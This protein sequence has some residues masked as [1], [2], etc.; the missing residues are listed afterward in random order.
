ME[1]CINHIY[2]CLLIAL[3]F[4]VFF[5]NLLVILAV[6]KTKRLRRVT[7]LYIVSLTV[8][9]LLVA[10]LILPFSIIR[11]YYG[12]WPYESHEL[13]LYFLSANIFLCVSSILNVC[14]ISIDRYIAITSPMKYI[15]KRT[16]QTALAMIIFA[17]SAS[18]IAMLP[19]LL[20]AQHHTGV[21]NC[22]V[23][24][25]AWYRILTGAL[26]FYI[27]FPLV[28]FIYLRIFWVIHSRRKAFKSVRFSSKLKEHRYGSLSILFQLNGLGRIKRWLRAD[29]FTKCRLF[30]LHSKKSEICTTY[31]SEN[32]CKQM[33]QITLNFSNKD[34]ISLKET[35]IPSESCS[36]FKDPN[37]QLVKGIS[38]TVTSLEEPIGVVQISL[39][40]RRFRF[41][42]NLVLPN[43]LEKR[44]SCSISENTASIYSVQDD[45]KSVIISTSDQ[46]SRTSENI[47]TKMH[48]KTDM[49]IKIMN[50]NRHSTSVSNRHQRQIF[51]KEQKSVRSVSI[52]VGCF[53]ICWIPFATVYL[54]E[55]IC[56]CLLSEKV[57]MTTGWI[58]Y[59][60]SLCNPFIYA[61]CNKEYADAF[62]RLLHLR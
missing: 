11:Q 23:R 12:Y 25:D 48:K 9:D 17:W 55:G 15:G 57:Y 58:A 36:T 21:R 20:G 29:D 16:R 60:N 8:A 46:H 56:E 62:R 59:I 38:D 19:P 41:V 22:Y 28:G 3:T 47:T 7:D 27:P 49:D 13:C 14:C 26:A 24:S 5:G 61:L 44:P 31:I 45:N 32:R 1:T 33:T 6:L 52:V 35:Y 40:P 10:V 18:F 34:D 39:V 53:M 42:E 54:V 37:I 4:I 2:Y 43:K 30:V 51:N 50:H